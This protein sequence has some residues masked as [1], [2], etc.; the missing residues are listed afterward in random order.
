MPSRK[1]SLQG[2]PYH[3]I[4]EFYKIAGIIF[5]RT[6]YCQTAGVILL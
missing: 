1:F 4:E 3:Y 5:D 2:K 6:N